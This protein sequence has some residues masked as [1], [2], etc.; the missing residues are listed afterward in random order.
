MPRDT[1]LSDR[2]L[3]IA[4][5][6][7]GISGLA[8][9]WLLSGIHEVTLYEQDDRLGGHANTVDVAGADGP[10]AVDTGFI[11]YNERNYPN[12]TAL[13]RHL[14]IATAASDM[15]FAVSLDDGA[16]EYSGASLPALFAQP[17][18]ALRPRF[19][20]MLADILRFYRQGP[21]VL[22]EPGSERLSLGAF[23]DRGGYS[24][25]FVSD[26]LLPM[27]AA[28]WSTPVGRMRDHPAAAFVRFAMNHGLM[29][30][31]G[32]PQ[33]RT[34]VGGSRVYV[35]RLVAALGSGVRR[36]TPVTGIVRLTDSVIVEDAGGGTA[37]FDHVVVATHADQALALLRQPS[38]EERRLLGAFGYSR[39]TAVL[40]SDPGWMPKRRRA[41]ASWNYLAR[42]GSG[43]A[44]ALC[45]TYWMNML[46]SLDQRRPLFVTL[47]P[48]QPPA[49]A[50]V[51]ATIAYDHP[52]FDTQALAAQRCLG[53]LQGAHRTWFCG[54]Y[55]G[56]GFHEDGLA[57][58]LDVA[59]RLGQVRRPW[60]AAGDAASPDGGRIAA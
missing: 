50:L 10:I 43:G 36:A 27:A 41:W 13:F 56:A 18:N 44:P 34:V 58:G 60:A 51:H 5:V 16:V 2:P 28:I 32:R 55:F 31:S 3:R 35:A 20:R 46:Q 4:V 54:S 53:S 30:L 8:A 40:H 15:S 39:N 25:A 47:N 45:V 1:P 29:Q 11:V 48:W 52:R 49:P 57:A 9:A 6:G 21:A 7:S 22:A 23:L 59:E 19:W 17:R 38:A 33:W 42:L 14:G 37:V 24:D 12:L 26:H